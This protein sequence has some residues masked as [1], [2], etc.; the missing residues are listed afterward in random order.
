M[1]LIPRPRATVCCGWAV[2]TF[3]NDPH[4]IL[5]LLSWHHV[6]LAVRKLLWTLQKLTA[7]LPFYQTTKS[8]C[9]SSGKMQSMFNMSQLKAWPQPVVYKAVW[10]M[11]LW[12]Y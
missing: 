7:T 8:T 3:E 9:A 11:Q 6:P 1:G 5:N 10:Q 4:N 12:L 2:I